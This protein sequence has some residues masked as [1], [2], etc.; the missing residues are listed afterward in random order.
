MTEDRKTDARAGPLP[1]GPEPLWYIFG[2]QI[3]RKTEIIALIAFV[4]SVSGLLLQILSNWRGAVVNLFPTDQLVITSTDKLGRNYAGKEN[5][6][7]V[8][9]TMSYV[10][11]GNV[12]HNAIIRRESITLSLA[13]REVEH[14]W[15]EFGSS[16][17]KNGV[18]VFDRKSEAHPIPVNAASAESHETLFTAWEID[19]ENATAPC[20]IGKNFMNWADFLGAIKAKKQISVTISAN[21]YQS[22]RAS[23]SCVVRLRDW[24]IQALEAQQWLAPACTE[25]SADGRPQRKTQ[26]Q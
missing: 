25:I 23:A 14:R 24:E 6:L 3:G 17:V 15:Y 18:L 4:L 7:A 5:M 8:M 2:L 22:N 20:D 19:C 13:D 1:P 21:V 11:S 10:N 16:D 9:A 12:G 26:R